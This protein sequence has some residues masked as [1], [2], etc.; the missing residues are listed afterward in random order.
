[1][2]RNVDIVRTVKSAFLPKR[3]AVKIDE[4]AATLWFRP[5]PVGQTCPA[6][7]IDLNRYARNLESVLAQYRCRLE[8]Q[9]YLAS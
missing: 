2:P 8:Q 9:G 1:M 4:E 3:C 7:T 5:M 6:V